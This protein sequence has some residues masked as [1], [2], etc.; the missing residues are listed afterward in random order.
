M[1]RGKST[2]KVQKEARRKVA[3]ANDIP[4]RDVAVNLLIL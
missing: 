4:L 1:S 3:D 2:C